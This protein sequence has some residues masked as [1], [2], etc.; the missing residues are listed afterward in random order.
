MHKRCTTTLKCIRGY[1]KNLEIG[2]KLEIS[3]E[4]WTPY[5]EEANKHI[6]C[7][8]DMPLIIWVDD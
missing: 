2:K 8:D 1:Q 6:V 3:Y 5:L 7:C 4:H